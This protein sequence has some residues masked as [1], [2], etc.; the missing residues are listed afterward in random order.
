M[1]RIKKIQKHIKVLRRY[2]GILYM[3][4]VIRKL[5]NCPSI[6]LVMPEMTEEN[7]EW[8]VLGKGEKV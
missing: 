8:I 2:G 4:Q 3:M 5:G 7:T 1:S 6:T